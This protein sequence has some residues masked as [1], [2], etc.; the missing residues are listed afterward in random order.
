MMKDF[1]NLQEWLES[2][3]NPLHFT[4]EGDNGS[5]VVAVVD[6]SYFNPGI[7]IHNYRETKLPNG[8]TIL[9]MAN[10]W[11]IRKEW[12][13]AIKG[14]LNDEAFLEIGGAE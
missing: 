14:L 12:L 1:R 10:G 3:G 2:Q 11:G 4:A 13:P 5:M 8:E 7:T 9:W 6:K